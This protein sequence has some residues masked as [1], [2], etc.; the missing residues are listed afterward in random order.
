[1]PPVVDDRCR[2]SGGRW[3]SAY[4]G[5]VTVDPAALEVDH[6]VPLADAWRSGAA[7]WTDGR[8]AAFANDLTDPV[9]LIAVSSHTNR[10]KGDSTPDQWLPPDRGAWCDYA[11]AWVDVKLTWRLT[12]TAPEKAT[13]V[14]V[15]GGC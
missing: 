5:L 10:S 6:L 7:A 15:L 11:T 14:Q 8:R 12:V 4:D 3:R 13:L 9:T 2:S 1:M